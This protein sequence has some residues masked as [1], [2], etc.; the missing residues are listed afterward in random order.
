MIINRFY[1][2]STDH[3]ERVKYAKKLTM[4]RQYSVAT[5][6]DWFLQAQQSKLFGVLDAPPPVD[7]GDHHRV[8]SLEAQTRWA[9]KKF[10][11]GWQ[12]LNVHNTH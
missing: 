1:S 5:L 9:N 10:T 7:T 8:V 12:A 4:L 11:G 2:L 6:F 3:H